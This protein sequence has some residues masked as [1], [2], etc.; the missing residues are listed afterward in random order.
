MNGDPAQQVNLAH[1]IPVLIVY[2]TVVVLEDGLVHSYDDIYHHRLGAREGPRQRVSVP[3]VR[4]RRR[5]RGKSYQRRT[6][7]TS[8]C[9]KFESR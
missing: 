5:L 9:T 1:P 7:P 3:L 4:R 2:A 8:T 6:G